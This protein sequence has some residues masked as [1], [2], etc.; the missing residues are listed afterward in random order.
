VSHR[1]LWDVHVVVHVGERDSDDL[2]MGVGGSDG[3]VHSLPA[4]PSG[5]SGERGAKERVKRCTGPKE[6][7]EWHARTALGI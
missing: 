4:V 6:G 1:L 3:A 7:L 5:T 2:P